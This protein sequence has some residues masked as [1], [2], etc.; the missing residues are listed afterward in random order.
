MSMKQRQCAPAFKKKPVALLVQN[1]S[2]GSTIRGPEE[3][4]RVQG[5]ASEGHVPPDRGQL[6]RS[7]RDPLA[8]TTK[9]PRALFTDSRVAI[10]ARSV[11]PRL[12]LHH[13]TQGMSHL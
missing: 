11:V 3:R 6:V 4:A 5:A 1:L 13:F 9:R 12:A 7:D 8:R 2:T 10:P